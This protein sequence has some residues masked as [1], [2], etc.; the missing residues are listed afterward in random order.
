MSFDNDATLG[1]ADWGSIATSAASIFTSINDSRT[2]SKAYASQSELM[3]LQMQ[4]DQQ[5][6]EQNQKLIKYALIGAGVIAVGI[7]LY[8]ALR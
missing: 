6:A 1:A 7:T 8:V 3:R 5:K 2:Q 4:A